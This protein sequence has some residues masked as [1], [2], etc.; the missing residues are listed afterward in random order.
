MCWHVYTQALQALLK[1]TGADDN[2]SLGGE[3]DIRREYL[4]NVLA[5]GGEGSGNLND[6]IFKSSNVQAL[7]GM[8]RHVEVSN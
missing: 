7:P 4:D 6:L 2:C 1:T 8:V 3:F 5:R